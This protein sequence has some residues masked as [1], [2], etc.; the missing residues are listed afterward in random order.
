M[1]D[2]GRTPGSDR[3]AYPDPVSTSTILYLIAIDYLASIFWGS[4][5]VAKEVVCTSLRFT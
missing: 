4:V 1:S 2:V 5:L 3:K